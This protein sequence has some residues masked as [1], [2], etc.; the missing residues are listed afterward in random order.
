MLEERPEV[1]EA[2]LE[3]HYA[4]DKMVEKESPAALADLLRESW[5]GYF[6]SQDTTVAAQRLAPDAESFAA[7]LGNMTPEDRLDPALILDCFEYLNETDGW[8]WNGSVDTGRLTAFGLY[9]A[10]LA[11]HGEPPQSQVSREE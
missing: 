1:V 8:G 11:A 3:A 9:D 10:V 5:N 4:A 7:L 2:F 6:R